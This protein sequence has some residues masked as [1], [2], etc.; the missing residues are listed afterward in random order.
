MGEHL[1]GLALLILSLSVKPG[2]PSVCHLNSDKIS[3]L[4][5]GFV[6]FGLARFDNGTGANVEARRGAV[7][8]KSH[9]V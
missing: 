9:A 7:S 5:C 8:R 1:P 3:N 4:G 6:E 2:P